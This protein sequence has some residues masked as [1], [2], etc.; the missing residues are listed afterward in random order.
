MILTDSILLVEPIGFEFNSQTAVDN[1]FQKDNNSSLAM[2]QFNAFKTTLVEAGV[3]VR[4]Y[5][6]KDQKTPDAL[7]PNNWFSTFPSGRMIVYPMMAQ[8]RR[9]EK[10]AD[11][12]ES[13]KQ[14]YPTLFD[15]STFEKS[16]DFLEGTGSLV[17][18]H[19][20][21]LAFACISKRTSL[22]AMSLWKKITSYNTITF[23]ANDE[24]GF[25][26][27]HTNVLLTLAENFA[28]LCE[29]AIIP[30]ERNKIIRSLEATGRAVIKISLDQM[31]KFGGNCIE[32][33]NRKGEHLL[34]MSEQ[35]RNAFNKDQIGLI[36]KYCQII[37]SDLSEIE[38]IGGGGA[39]CMIAELF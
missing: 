5:T 32:L 3:N 24:T 23:E 21:K 18:D 17:I 6:P 30:A 26:I 39:R 4:I 25:P 1:K 9:L 37:S 27:Y 22:V 14:D 20:L 10:R 28:I 35:A 31:K 15:L 29:E 2:F 16:E 7:F 19:E 11:L 12:I 13:L 34:V 36:E 33:K 38:T 8:N